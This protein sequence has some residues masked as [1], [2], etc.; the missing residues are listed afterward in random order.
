MQVS[1]IFGQC[2][3]KVFEDTLAKGGIIKALC[4]PSGA[5]KIFKCS[6]KKGDVY[7]QAIKVGAKRL[8]FLKV[9]DNGK[10]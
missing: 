3:F 4:V 9:L 7:N 2:D 8:Y 10:R 5:K 6:I 1:D